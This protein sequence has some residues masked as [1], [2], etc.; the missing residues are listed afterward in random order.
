MSDS[1]INSQESPGKIV[2][3][4]SEKIKE[5]KEYLEMSDSPINSQESP[6][7]IV[8]NEPE[9]IKELKEYLEIMLSYGNIET[10]EIREER[11]N[12]IMQEILNAKEEEKRSNF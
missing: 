1:P 7:K 5:L 11:E 3:N 6:G 4:E 9:K 2:Y 8:Y 10:Q 12:R